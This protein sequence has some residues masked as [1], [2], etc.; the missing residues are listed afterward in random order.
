MDR[1][2]DR[3]TER[4][5][6]VT[7][8][9]HARRGLTTLSPIPIHTIFVPTTICVLVVAALNSLYVCYSLSSFVVCVMCL[10]SYIW[11]LAKCLQTINTDILNP[12]LHSPYS[13]HLL[14]CKVIIGRMPRSKRLLRCA[15]LQSTL[16]LFFMLATKTLSLETFVWQPITK[17]TEQR[18]PLTAMQ[19]SLLAGALSHAKHHW[20][21]YRQT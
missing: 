1:Q 8:A 3:Q 2:T 15:R 20:R 12:I 13:F 10:V 21:N 5:Y 11:L 17:M 9:A 18:L 19:L 6:T 16:S 4:V 14:C 7:L